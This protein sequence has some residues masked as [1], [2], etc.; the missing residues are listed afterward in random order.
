ML[1]ALAEEFNKK[2]IEENKM[3]SSMK[4]KNDFRWPMWPKIIQV[5]ATDVYVVGGNNLTCAN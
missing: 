2:E 4:E 1:E 3:K 5:N